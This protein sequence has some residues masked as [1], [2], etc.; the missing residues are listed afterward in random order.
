MDLVDPMDLI[1]HSA[2]SFF[3]HVQSLPLAGARE[4]YI[5]GRQLSP[6]GGGSASQPHRE[7]RT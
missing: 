3:R 4:V 2:G 6:R 7:D 5:K 1:G